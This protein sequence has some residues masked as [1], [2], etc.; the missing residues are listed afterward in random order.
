MGLSDDGCVALPESGDKLTAQTTAPLLAPY[1]LQRTTESAA[2][3]ADARVNSV[4]IYGS[5]R[6]RTV[7]AA[8]GC[9]ALGSDASWTGVDSGSDDI[10]DVDRPIVSSGN[11]E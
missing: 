3:T 9:V 5:D 10:D 2:A 6:H 8:A 4:Y 1:E 11:V 7:A